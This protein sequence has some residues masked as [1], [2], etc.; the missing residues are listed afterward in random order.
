MLCNRP[1]RSCFSIVALLVLCCSLSVATDEKRRPNILFLLGDQWRAQALGYAGN[2]DVRTPNLDRLAAESVDFT[3]AV[4]GIPVCC[5]MRASLATGQRP[6]THGVFLND[7]Q[8]SADSTTMAEVLRSAG[9]DTGYIGKWHL[10]G[11]GRS[12]FIPPERRQGFEYWKV[13]ECTHKYNRSHYYADGPEKL[14]WDGYDAF[15]Q[16]R[17][18]RAYIRKHASSKKP[19]LLVLSWGPPHAPYHTAPAKYRAMYQPE[20]LCLRPNVPAEMHGRVRKD[21]AGYYAHCTALDDCVGQLRQ[22]LAETG[23]AKDTI[24]VFTADHGD[25][26][27]SH[28]FYKKQQPY[29]ESVRVPMLFHYPRGL[30]TEG[31]RLD[32]PINCEDLMPTLLGLAGVPGPASVEGL[33]YAAHMRGGADPSDGVALLTCPSPFG[34][35]S[36]QKGGREYRGLRTRRHTYARDLRGPWLLFDNSKDPYQLANLVGRPEHAALVSKFDAM[37]QRRLDA[38]GDKFL[39]STAYIKKWGYKVNKN[40]TVPYTN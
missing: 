7:V 36:R 40:G 3:R 33:N 5:P 11:R 24:L 23:V 29:E 8:L 14:T 22:T 34:Q 39:P 19:F 31:R 38:N 26:L 15:A 13:L 30:G 35:W 28:G 20:K 18:A 17:D 10:D 32:A 12:N 25:L 9:Y 21:L 27:G 6:L 2:T 16:T 4:V 37:L 1:G